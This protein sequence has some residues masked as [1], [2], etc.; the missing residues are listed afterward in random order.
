MR[1]VL[2]PELVELL[3]TVVKFAHTDCPHDS[4]TQ[5]DCMLQEAFENWTA[6]ELICT[7]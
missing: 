5:V 4:V 2:L 1:N 7:T 6:L 3:A